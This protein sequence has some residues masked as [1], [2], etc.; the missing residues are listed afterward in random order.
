MQLRRQHNELFTELFI[1]SF[2]AYTSMIHQIPCNNMVAM[3]PSSKP[4]PDSLSR[5][6]ARTQTGRQRRY[7]PSLY[8]YHIT[9][10]SYYIRVVVFVGHTPLLIKATRWRRMVGQSHARPLKQPRKEPPDAI[11]YEAVCNF[12]HSPVTSSLLGPNTHLST[13]FSDTFSLRSSLKTA[14]VV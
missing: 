13:L 9:A 14:S 1:K 11:A 10:S 3:L 4:P 2:S 12:P 6:H 7:F 5:L 8:G